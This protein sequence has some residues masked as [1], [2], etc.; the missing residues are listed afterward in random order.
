MFLD[1]RVAAVIAVS[2]LPSLP[3][4]DKLALSSKTA[5]LGEVSGT[6]SPQALAGLSAHLGEVRGDEG[7]RGR[8]GDRGLDEGDRGLGDRETVPVAFAQET[9]PAE[10]VPAEF[11]QET[12]PAEARAFSVLLS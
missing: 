2:K 8:P 1:M 6:F 11:A 5:V 3:E 10:A 9:V 4:L 12:V 7:D